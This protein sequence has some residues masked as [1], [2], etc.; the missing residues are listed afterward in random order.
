MVDLRRTVIILMAVACVIN[1]IGII[2]C[3]VNYPYTTSWYA[4]R[5]SYSIIFPICMFEQSEQ[6]L[7][8]KLFFFL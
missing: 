7:R 5:A 3:H 4:Y 2:H 6:E 1:V 8:E